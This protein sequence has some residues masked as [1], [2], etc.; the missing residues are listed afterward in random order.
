[1]AITKTNFINYTRCPRYAALDEVHKE[2]LDADI[3][4]KE[5]KDQELKENLSEIVSSIYEIDEETGEEISS[6]NTTD[7][8]ADDPFKD[9]G[10][11]VVLSDDDLPF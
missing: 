2:K 7:I 1:M 5:Y 4:Y 8:S 9:F 11:E 6:P 3:S 10:E